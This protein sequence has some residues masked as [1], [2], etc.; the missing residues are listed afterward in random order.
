MKRDVDGDDDDG[1]YGTPLLAQPTT[2]EGLV[3]LVTEWK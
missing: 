1:D 2:L 3:D